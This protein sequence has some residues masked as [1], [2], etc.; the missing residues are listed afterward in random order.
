MHGYMWRNLGPLLK[1]PHFKVRMIKWCAM[2]I[3]NLG[4]DLWILGS[5][6]RTLLLDTD[7][8]MP[9]SC[10]DE[11]LQNGWIEFKQWC[12]ANKWESLIL[13]EMWEERDKFLIQR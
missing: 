8:W 13:K 10:D 7:A 11:R 2:H 9:A 6:F 4:C 5:W 3:L 12:R 1:V